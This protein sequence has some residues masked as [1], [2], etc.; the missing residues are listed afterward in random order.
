MSVNLSGRVRV[1]HA[2]QFI[3]AYSDSPG[4]HYPRKGSDILFDLVSNLRSLQIFSIIIGLCVATASGALAETLEPTSDADGDGVQY[5]QDNCSEVANSSQI[6][7]DGDGFGNA[8]DADYDNDGLVT[9][10]DY[11][12]FGDAFGSVQGG[13]AY[14]AEMDADFDGAIW[15]ADFLMLD[16]YMWLEPGPSGLECTKGDSDVPCQSLL[17]LS[18][19]VSLVWDFDKDGVSD[20]ED[21]CLLVAN[22]EQHDVDKDG[23]GNMCDADYNND[24][25][26]DDADWEILDAAWAAMKGI[27]EE[28]ERKSRYDPLVDCDSDDLIWSSDYLLLGASWNRAPGPSGLVC[29]GVKKGACK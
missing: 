24:G 27:K 4:L 3:E 15:D 23:F 10:S 8:C 5:S 12:A 17:A 25:I 19:E 26:V 9:G 18:A 11:E 2:T 28:G 1:G 22:S 21:N 20:T 16:S 7:S 14:R 29:A 6:D 13:S